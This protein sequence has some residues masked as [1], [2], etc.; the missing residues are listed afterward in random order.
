MQNGGRAEYWENNFYLGLWAYP[1]V[2]YA[3]WKK[4]RRNLPL[5]ASCAAIF[6]LCFDSPLL[7][8]VYAVVPG[9]KLFRLHSRMLLLEQLAVLVLAGRGLDAALKEGRDGKS[10]RDFS[11]AWAAVALL[12]LAAAARWSSAPLAVSSLGLAAAALLFFIAER[13][14][15]API[16]FLALLPLLDNGWRLMPVTAPIPEIFPEQAFY[17]PL[18]REAL[19]GRVAA[20]GRAAIP[21]GAAGYLGIDMANGYEP[22]NLK[23]FED[24][25][26]V[27]KYG[28][29]R[30]RPRAPVVWTDLESISKPEMLRAL[31]VE[32]LV[33]SAPQ[34]L[35]PL[36]FE[37]AGRHD[38]VPVFRFYQGMIRAPVYVWK[39]RRPL[40]P[41]YYAAAVR[42]VASETDSLAAVAAA[43]SVRDA[44]VLDLDRPTSALDYSGGTARMTRRG[45][46]ES[47][48]RLESRGENFL[49][50]S[51]IW[52]PGWRARLDGRD[53]PLYRTNHALLGCFIPPGPHTLELAMTSP[54]LRGGLGLFALGAA[55][56]AFLCLS[57]ASGTSHAKA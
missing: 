23:D 41:A 18:K 43:A 53:I 33:A 20:I 6:V 45:Y 56:L 17:G 25:F 38:D 55:L 44:N 9:F 36:G 3:C 19:N 52:Y 1:P 39:D 37:A 32:F 12:G 2:L 31:D 27:L 4:G 35:E 49:I 13:V 10:S 47:V 8:L 51:Q 24:Y 14:R 21:Y 30:A 15:P 42:A 40:G 54:A 29:A 48:Y 5:I 16:L 28:G 34:S 50:L 26:S 46:N 7:R 57:S 11:S 22:L